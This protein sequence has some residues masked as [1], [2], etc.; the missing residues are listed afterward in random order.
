MTPYM[1]FPDQE[2]E[3]I[4]HFLMFVILGTGMIVFIAITGMLFTLAVTIVVIIVVKRTRRLMAGRRD[5]DDDDDDDTLSDM[6]EGF[7]LRG[8]HH[9]RKES[10]EGI[11][12][13]SEGS[14]VQDG[15]F[16]GLHPL[17]RNEVVTIIIANLNPSV[18]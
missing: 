5:D 8:F 3:N 14:K 12:V 1:Q 10:S 9:Q 2:Q 4:N 17:S 7:I 11:Y 15:T 13:F 16:S 18:I 6:E